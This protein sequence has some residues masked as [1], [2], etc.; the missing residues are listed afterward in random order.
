[1]KLS[2]NNT[3]KPKKITKTS[4]YLESKNPTYHCQKTSVVL[5]LNDDL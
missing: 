4:H 1:M 5:V 3:Q 2:F